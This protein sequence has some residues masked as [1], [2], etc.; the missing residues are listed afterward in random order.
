MNVGNTLGHS[1]HNFL[2]TTLSKSLKNSP[3][4]SSRELLAGGICLGVLSIW[5]LTGEPSVTR[6]AQTAAL[7]T[8]YS[9]SVCL[10]SMAVFFLL[11][12][13]IVWLLSL[14]FEARRSHPLVYYA[15][16][17]FTLL[18][19]LLI[20][21]WP[22]SIYVLEVEKVVPHIFLVKVISLIGANALLYY[23]IYKMTQE[24][25]YESEK[26]YVKSSRFKDTAEKNYLKEKAVWLFLSQ[27]GTVFFYL[28][29]FS[30]IPDLMT[31]QPSD[32]QGI[33]GILFIEIRE[34][35]WSEKLWVQMITMIPL[36][37]AVR[38]FIDMP[39]RKWE[40]RRQL[41]KD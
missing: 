32:I 6:W 20:N 3:W 30:L 17:L 21:V 9:L 12:L 19:G 4:L 36:V 23:F 34:V 27:A 39:L 25:V 37:L 22:V 24:L 1:F 2:G 13:V 41:L 7:G 5:L 40:Y 8:I 38:Y 31:E 11:N 18:L 15:A 35:G 28:F 26:L 33:M 14:T 29:S 16:I 10:F